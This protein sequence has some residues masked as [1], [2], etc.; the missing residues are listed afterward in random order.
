MI[1]VKFNDKA[2]QV[3]A[4]TLDLSGSVVVTELPQVGEEHTIYELHTTTPSIIS[5]WIYVNGEWVN[6]DENLEFET[7]EK[8]V[9]PSTNTQKITPD[10]GYDG[11]SKV[12]V[13]AVTNAID[14]NI[15]SGNI[16]KDVAILGV[17]GTYEGEP[18][19]LQDKTV[20]PTT[21]KQEV[22]ADENYDGLSKVTI[23]AIE[24]QNKEI[25]P[26][27]SSQSV[28]PDKGYD[29]LCEVTVNAIALQDKTVTPDAVRQEIT[30][31]SNYNGLGK[32]IVEAVEP[33]ELQDKTVT[34][35]TEIQR[36]TADEDYYGLSKVTVEAVELQDKVTKPTTSSQEVVPDKG[37]VGL[38]K[39]TI[40]GINLQDKTVSPTTNT[41]KIV[42]DENYDGLGK[43]TINAVT[44]TIDSNIK[45]ENI[46]KD[47]SI[48]GVTGTYE[49]ID[50]IPVPSTSLGVTYSNLR[51]EHPNVP[52]VNEA[53]DIYYSEE[54]LEI[55]DY[56]VFYPETEEPEPKVAYAT[57][58]G[59]PQLTSEVHDFV[60]TIHPKMDVDTE[61]DRLSISVNGRNVYQS[62]WK[63]EI[64][65]EITVS[66]EGISQIE[67]DVVQLPL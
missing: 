51:I 58:S 63:Q 9:S 15:V 66:V 38:G 8:T 18:V 2:K 40:D 43:V 22:L 41:Q 23:E 27:T 33:V 16:K 65:P 20:S 50:E 53:V 24:L 7:Q 61:T 36:V 54:K 17:T 34:P 6:I 1:Q 25:S 52:N 49:G 31:D 35:T 32:V 29:G 62:Q 30:Y 46:K 45:S 56:Y 60:L 57:V 26:S 21:I 48:L 5:Y 13:N 14:K 4:D 19:E 10:E 47:V 37:Y 42:A 3:L 28:I 67:I 11:L 55:N 12:I 59:L 64:P 44:N 39:V